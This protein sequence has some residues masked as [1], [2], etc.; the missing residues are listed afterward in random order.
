MMVLNFPEAEVGLL[1]P[2][3][4]P[5]PVDHNSESLLETNSFPRTTSFVEIENNV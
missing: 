1:R 3:E 5:N 2:L 4:R